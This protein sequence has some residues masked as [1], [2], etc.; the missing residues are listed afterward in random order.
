VARAAGHR[1]Q[2]CAAAALRDL[3]GAGGTACRSTVEVA[4][5]PCPLACLIGVSRPYAPPPCHDYASSKSHAQ[6]HPAWPPAFHKRTRP[7]PP[8]PPPPSLCSRVR[9][10][11]LVMNRAS[12]A[13]TVENLFTLSFLVRDNKVALEVGGRAGVCV[14]CVCGGGGVWG[15]GVQA[16]LL[17][18]R[19]G[20]LGRWEAGCK[21]SMPTDAGQRA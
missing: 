17:E 11:D 16:A 5:Q 18:A 10:L 9:L 14:L 13:Q 7:A 20:L 21:A 12:F 1:R 3:L 2:V 15:G 19:S 8:P 6:V 4:F